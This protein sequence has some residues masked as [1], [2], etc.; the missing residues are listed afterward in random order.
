MGRSGRSL[1]FPIDVVAELVGVRQLQ[2]R[3]VERRIRKD[4]ESAFEEL[5]SL[6]SVGACQGSPGTSS[7]TVILRT[8][9]SVGYA[10]VWALSRGLTRQA[11]SLVLSYDF[12]GG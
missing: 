2:R 6:L 5:P 12:S 9:H 11:P 7:I 4:P 3:P 10:H 8:S 1:Q